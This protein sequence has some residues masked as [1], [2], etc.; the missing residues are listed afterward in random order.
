MVKVVRRSNFLGVVAES[1]WGCDQ[2]G[3]EGSRRL[4]EIARRCRKAK[5]WDEVRDQGCQDG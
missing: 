2:G 4:V 1:E 5:L 3:A